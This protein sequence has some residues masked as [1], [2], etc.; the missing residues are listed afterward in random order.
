MS[1]LENSPEK[2]KTQKFEKGEFAD[3]KIINEEWDIHKIED[4]SLLRS[5]ILL[6]GIMIAEKNL[7]KLVTELKAGNKQA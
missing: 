6:S 7:G 5:R 3:F 2:E 1:Q 4:G